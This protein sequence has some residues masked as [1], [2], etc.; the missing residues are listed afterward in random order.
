M[1]I[2]KLA[3]LT[4][5]GDAPGMNACIRAVVRTAAFYGI[6]VVGVE[7]GYE[8]LINKEF[9]QL[10]TRSVSFIINQGGTILYT[11]R[12]EKFRT[13]EGRALAAQNLQ[14]AGVSALVVIGG[15]GSFRGA[16]KLNEEHNI[17][18]IGL[19]ATI[20][21]DIYGTDLTIGFT[22]ALNTATEAIDKIRDTA[23]SHN[24]LFLVEVM[25]RNSGALA[26]SVGIAIGAK[27]TLV[28]ERKTT[29]HELFAQLRKGVVEN[30]K[31][32]I[33]VI[34]EGSKLGNAYNLAKDIKEQF[35]QFDIRVSILGHVQ[36][37]GNPCATD[38]ILASQLGVA[39]VEGLIDGK[40]NCM[41]GVQNNQLIYRSLNEVVENQGQENEEYLRIANILS[42]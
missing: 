4:S 19:P 7:N 21:N 23:S 17:P 29:K 42:I 6:D 16:Q 24:R 13:E 22:T 9:K 28:P 36:R 5:G 34:A 25:G 2:N 11:A 33:I 18:V 30:K 31:S 37:G 26:V 15:D 39:A 38:R 8:G 10:E 14:S 32:N 35:D 1:K 40:S 12:S 3:V 20:D 27:A 41:A